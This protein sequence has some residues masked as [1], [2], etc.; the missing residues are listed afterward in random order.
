[1]Q[2]L[3]NRP[4]LQTVTGR[5]WCA[6]AHQS[7]EYDVE[8][9]AHALSNI[10]RYSGHCR[11]FYSVAQH[12]VVVMRILRERLAYPKANKRLLQAALLHDASEA[13][14]LDVPSPIKRMEM[15]SQ[16]K[17]WEHAVGTSIMVYFGLEFEYKNPLIKWADLSALA[18][19]KRDIMGNSPHD[20][21]WLETVDGT[22][23]PAAVW[24]IKPLSPKQAKR[25]FMRTW[26]SIQ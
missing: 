10:C 26:E 5:A 24:S 18:T 15:M 6:D 9:I 7:Y 3:A 11:E 2:S 8:E 20:R 22:L 14:C 25:L 1:M 13:F 17:A 4:W 21:M 19:E 12:S 23:P 16:Y